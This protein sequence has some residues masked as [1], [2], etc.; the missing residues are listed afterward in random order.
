MKKEYPKIL[1]NG[2]VFG[3]YSPLYH[4]KKSEISLLELEEGNSAD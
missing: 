1:K 4:N 2:M 3:K